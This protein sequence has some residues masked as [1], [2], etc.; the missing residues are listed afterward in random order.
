[1]TV[2]EPRPAPAILNAP[3]CRS[4]PHTRAVPRVNRLCALAPPVLQAAEADVG[5]LR[6]RLSAAGEAEEDLRR[7]KEEVRRLEATLTEL[8]GASDAA[9]GQ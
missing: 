7:A 3:L 4:T 6:S 8:A 9:G 5:L 2:D 1:V